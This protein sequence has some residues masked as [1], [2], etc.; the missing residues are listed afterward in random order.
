MIKSKHLKPDM[1]V[2]HQLIVPSFWS[3][4]QAIKCLPQSTLASHCP[5][6]HILVVVEY[7]LLPLVPLKRMHSSHLS[8]LDAISYL[9]PSSVLSLLL[10]FLQLVQTCIYNLCVEFGHNISPRATLCVGLLL[11]QHHVDSEYPLVGFFFSTT[12]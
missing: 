11:N 10:P 8:I 1:L 4:L 12:W 9:P 2:V 3:L 7:R 6:S 5:F